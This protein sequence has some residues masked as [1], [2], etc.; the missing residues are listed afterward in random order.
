MLSDDFFIVEYGL[1]VDFVSYFNNHRTHNMLKFNSYFHIC[2]GSIV[3]KSFGA[4][5]FFFLP[6]L[7]G[8]R[9]TGSPPAGGGTLT[10]WLFSSAK[11]R[12]NCCWSRPCR[13]GAG[14]CRGGRIRSCRGWTTSSQPAAG[15]TPQIS[16]LCLRTKE[17]TKSLRLS[18]K[19][20]IYINRQKKSSLTNLQNDT[21]K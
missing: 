21:K 4:Y 16:L 13:R 9:A 14:C 8:R 20:K 7:Q 2:N 1:F 5:C 18:Q 19:T 15:A 12:P 17:T 10:C 3:K 6:S 11:S